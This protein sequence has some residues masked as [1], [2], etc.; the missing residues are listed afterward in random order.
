[1]ISALADQSFPPWNLDR[2]DQTDLPLNKIY[3]YDKVGCVLWNNTLNREQCLSLIWNHLMYRYL[4]YISPVSN[5]SLVRQ[6]GSGVTAF[7][8]DTGIRE[9]HLDFGGRA[10]CK[11]SFVPTQACEDG[12]GHG[13]H[14]AGE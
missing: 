6:N 3:H 7:I 1:M 13:T 2:V 5:L 9:T 10:K 11:I 4:I 14:V 8:I 12:H